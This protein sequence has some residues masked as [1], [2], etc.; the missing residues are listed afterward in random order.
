[1]VGVV[2]GGRRHGCMVEWLNGEGLREGET[3]GQRD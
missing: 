2:G 1:M 3:E